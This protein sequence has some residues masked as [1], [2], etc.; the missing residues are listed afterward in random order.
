MIIDAFFAAI[1]ASFFLI[2]LYKWG[3]MEE[4][5]SSAPY[6]WLY[7]LLSCNFCIGF[8]IG[9]I[10]GTILFICGYEPYYYM[11]MGSLTSVMVKTFT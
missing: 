1:L 9:T 2:L 4:L 8:W 3:I 7:K 10:V 6:E 11:F 5:Q